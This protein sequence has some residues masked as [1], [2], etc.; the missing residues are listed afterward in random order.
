MSRPK[1]NPDCL[2]CQRAGHRCTTCEFAYRQARQ[3]RHGQST[4]ARRLVEEARAYV[5]REKGANP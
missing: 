5:L 1:L 4:R 3:D 2:D